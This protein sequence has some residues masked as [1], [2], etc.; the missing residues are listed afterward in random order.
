V[1]WRPAFGLNLTLT[2]GQHV[3]GR[4]RNR[5]GPELGPLVADGGRHEVRAPAFPACRSA[6]SR[7]RRNCSSTLGTGTNF[8]LVR[9]GGALGRKISWRPLT[10]S[11]CSVAKAIW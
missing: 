2:L 5:H 7:A 8:T 11:R 6:P 4:I 3:A 10:M 1:F 9:S